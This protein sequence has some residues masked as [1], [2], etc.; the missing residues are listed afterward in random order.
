MD[1]LHFVHQGHP[2]T[3]REHR[4]QVFAARSTVIRRAEQRK[5]LLARSVR[6][7]QEATYP[8]D[9][10]GTHS[11]STS[12]TIP[13]QHTLPP[14]LDHEWSGRLQQ[15]LFG[16][17]PGWNMPNVAVSM[18]YC[19]YSHSSVHSNPE[20]CSNRCRSI[21]WF[22]THSLSRLQSLWLLDV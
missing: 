17:M 7:V 22:Y 9:N 18:N 2:T 15:Q 20:A 13:R 14:G 6:H 16:G 11:E 21:L 8:E 3:R 1:D 5:V 19:K 12:D 10:E 4:L